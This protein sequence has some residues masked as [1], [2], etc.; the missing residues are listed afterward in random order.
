MWD[1]SN[2]KGLESILKTQFPGCTSVTE[3][4]QSIR[5]TKQEPKPDGG[6]VPKVEPTAQER[7][8]VNEQ[9]YKAM[10][11][12]IEEIEKWYDPDREYD[13]AL[14]NALDILPLNNVDDVSKWK[15]GWLKLCSG[16]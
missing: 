14:K 4:F 9:N 3:A 8:S 5:K 12:A 10:S 1:Q 7:E 15:R 2:N 16:L 13:P 6:S 11:A